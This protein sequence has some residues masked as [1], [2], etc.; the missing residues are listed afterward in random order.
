MRAKNKGPGSRGE[1]V[2]YLFSADPRRPLSRFRLS[3][4][5]LYLQTD[6]ISVEARKKEVRNEE[7]AAH[8]SAHYSDFC[9]RDTR[10][11]CGINLG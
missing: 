8:F 11:P 9:L 2:P 5:P 10:R 7:I 6:I 1:T 3:L 4:I